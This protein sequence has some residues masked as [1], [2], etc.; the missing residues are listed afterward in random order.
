MEYYNNPSSKFILAK[1]N[2]SHTN[3]S[4]R[5]SAGSI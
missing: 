4:G 5:D 2:V 1:E 3:K